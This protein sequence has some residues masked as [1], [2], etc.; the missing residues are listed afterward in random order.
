MFHLRHSFTVTFCPCSNMAPLPRDAIL[1][2]LILSGLCTGSTAL[3][4][5][6]HTTESIRIK[7]LQ[8]RSPT[9]GSSPQIPCSW[10]GSSPWAAAPS[11]SLF[12]WGSP[13][14]AASFRTDP[15]APQVAAWR[16]AHPGLQGNEHLLPSL[17]TDLGVC[18][19]VFHSS[20]LTLPATVA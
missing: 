4:V 19:T 6:V 15:P 2:E 11:W 16:S 10:V 7:L 18:K 9:G 13:Q 20:L 5:W 1:P 3:Q 14:A 12:L 17:F 8:H